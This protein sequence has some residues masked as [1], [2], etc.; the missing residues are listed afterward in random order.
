V[1]YFQKLNSG[2]EERTALIIDPM[3]APAD[4][5][6]HHECS[7]RPAAWQIKGSSWWPCRMESIACSSFI[8]MWIIF[9]APL[10]SAE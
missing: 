2:M 6:R 4:P 10:M 5:D 1:T 7:K 3:L 9:T 8:L